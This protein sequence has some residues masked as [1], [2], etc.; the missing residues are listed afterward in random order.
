M[1]P[2]LLHE[3]C[4]IFANYLEQERLMGDSISINCETNF[5]MPINQQNCDPYTYYNYLTIGDSIAKQLIARDK[6]KF[7][8]KRAPAPTQRP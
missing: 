6:A 8:Q 7:E 2:P 4:K 1:S 3:F 5:G